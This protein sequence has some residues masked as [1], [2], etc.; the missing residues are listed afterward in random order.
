MFPGS[1]N[2]YVS[3]GALGANS[4]TQ[5]KKGGGLAG[6]FIP[7][8]TGTIALFDNA[9]GDTSGVALMPATACTAGTPLLID[10]LFQTGLVVVL[11]GGAN[12]AL[13]YN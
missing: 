11:G 4:T 13:L 2:Q 5:I 9:A 12:G 6:R 7:S 3:S 1:S 8:V 10:I